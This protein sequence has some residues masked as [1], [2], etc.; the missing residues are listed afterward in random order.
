MCAFLLL[1]RQP[2]NDGQLTLAYLSNTPSQGNAATG[3]EAL[4]GRAKYLHQRLGGGGLLGKGHAGVSR[5][6]PRCEGDLRRQGKREHTCTHLAV[7][8]TV[9]FTR[10][11]VLRESQGSHGH[12]T[13]P[14]FDSA[15]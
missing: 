3:L 5:A 10:T 12:F 15:F 13:A 7:I 14:F 9:S 6:Q 8:V 4:C 1:L 2:R 11:G